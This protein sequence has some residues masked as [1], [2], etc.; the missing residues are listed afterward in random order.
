[1]TAKERLLHDIETFDIEMFYCP[2]KNNSAISAADGYIGLNPALR[3]EPT[4]LT[5]V[6]CHE[7]G[8][9]HAG[10]FYY[11]YSPF[12]LRSQ[13]EYRADKACTLRYVPYD[14]MID[15]MR[16]GIETRCE[17]AEAFGVTEE[18]IEKSYNYYKDVELTLE[19]ISGLKTMLDYYRYLTY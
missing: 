18:L 11:G 7:M 14:E 17:L 12:E 3:A 13:A 10:A 19:Q 1:M 16:Q 8:H 9:F 5:T 15:L 6:L 4:V 2:L